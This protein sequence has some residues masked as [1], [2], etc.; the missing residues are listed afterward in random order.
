MEGEADTVVG[1][2]A[3]E[4]GVGTE[5]DDVVG[6]DEESVVEV[7]LLGRMPHSCANSMKPVATV[8]SIGCKHFAQVV[9]VVPLSGRNGAQE[10][11]NDELHAKD[12]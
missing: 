7:A 11:V 4:V 10:H 8:G 9:T 2:T 1:V 6:A 5:A 12:W 3:N